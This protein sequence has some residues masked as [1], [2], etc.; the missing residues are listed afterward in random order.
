V[1]PSSDRSAIASFNVSFVEGDVTQLESLL[2]PVSKADT[3]FHL[4]ASTTSFT[5]EMHIRVNVG[6]TGNIARACSEAEQT[7]K[8]IIVSSSGAVG[9]NPPGRPMVETDPPS[10]VSMYGRSKLAGEN[11]ARQWAGKVPITIVRPAIVFGEYERDMFRMFQLVSRGWHLVVGMKAKR[12]SL[13]H[14]ADLTKAL[15]LIAS[16]GERLPPPEQESKS[17]GQG[18]YFVADDWAP[19]YAELGPMLAESLGRKARLIKIPGPVVWC[20]AL[21]FE[22]LNR[23]RREPSILNLD[24]AREGMSGDWVYSTQKVKDH[25]GFIPDATVKERIIQTGKWYLEQGW[26]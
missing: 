19:T 17:K 15:M 9:P 20:I 5:E 13:I 7:P 1:R 26:L 2:E 6:G 22:V 16:N 25:L 8:L 21:V 18:I 10:P 12:L 24:K 3:V 4:A 14:A 11:A 23:V